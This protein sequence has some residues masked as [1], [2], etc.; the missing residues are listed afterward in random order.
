VDREERGA[1]WWGE[2]EGRGRGG[3]VGRRGGDRPGVRGRGRAGGGRGQR[4]EGRR[5]GG[6]GR[7][8]GG[9][10]GVAGGRRPRGG[11]GV[12]EIER[13]GGAAGGGGG[14]GEGHEF[15]GRRG[16]RSR[17]EVVG[18]CSGS[19]GRRSDNAGPSRRSSV[20]IA[21]DGTP[22]VAWDDNSDGDAE[23]Y[24]RRWNGSSW[25]E[26]GS[27]SAS[28][29]GISDNSGDSWSP[30]AAIAAERHALHR[31]ARLQPQRGH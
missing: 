31:P 2:G 18:S 29:G 5:G 3:G 8:G 11:G 23:I 10:R 14:G 27:G 12:L 28:G 19:G 15:E 1:T 25:E 4:R 7:L 16:R 6:A 24:V 22:Y 30:S 17:W 20:L 21:P 9:G 13:G 26:V